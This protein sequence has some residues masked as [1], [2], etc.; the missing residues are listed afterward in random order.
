MIIALILGMRLPLFPQVQ[1]QIRDT[2]HNLSMSGP[3]PFKALEESRICR[4]CHT[5]HAA[6]PKQPLWNH[7]LSQGAYYQTYQSPTFDAALSGQTSFV[8]DGSSK[9]CLGCHDGTV[10]LGAFRGSSRR[11]RGPESLGALPPGAR[12]YIGT[13]L[14]GSHPIS[15]EVTASLIAANNAKDTPLKSVIEMKSDERVRLDSSNKVQCTSCHDAHSDANFASSG[16]HFWA[17]PTFSEVC[18]VCHLY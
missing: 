4:F 15:F 1:G 2:K 3:G 7:E 8:P 17:K 5:T 6:A 9:L 18:I 16:I 13:D 12:G 14:S 10:A 11:T